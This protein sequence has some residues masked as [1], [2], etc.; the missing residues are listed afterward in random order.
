MK[1]AFSHTRAAIANSLEPLTL[2]RGLP[3]QLSTVSPCISVHASEHRN[4]RCP[5]RNFSQPTERL[6]TTGCMTRQVTWMRAHITCIDIHRKAHIMS[7][8]QRHYP[9]GFLL[10]SQ[11]YRARILSRINTSVPASQEFCLCVTQSRDEKD[12][13]GAA[14]SSLAALLSFGLSAACSPAFLPCSAWMIPC[15]NPATAHTYTETL[16]RNSI[17]RCMSKFVPMCDGGHIL[18]SCHGMNVLRKSQATRQR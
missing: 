9:D 2:R 5:G 14:T 6:W 11:D 17:A 12:H 13:F 7:D 3:Y 18:Q 1:V 4:S 10:L 16:S 8:E 15:L